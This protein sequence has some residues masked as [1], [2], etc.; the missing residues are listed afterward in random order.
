MQICSL[1]KKHEKILTKYIK[2]IQGTVYHATEG[3]GSNKFT[4]FNEIIDN[5]INYVNAFN[6]IVKNT[7]DK[8]TEWVYLTPNLIMYATMGFLAGL[9]NKHNNEYIEELTEDMFETTVEF[10]GET[11]DI[12]YDIK[13]KEERQKKILKLTKTKNEHN[14]KH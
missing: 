2:F 10:I 7:K 9:K 12:L 6:R 1:N 8:R 13:V 14:H 3:Y 4:D 5:I 11:T